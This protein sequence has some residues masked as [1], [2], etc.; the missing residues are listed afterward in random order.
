MTFPKK[1]PATIPMRGRKPKDPSIKNAV[2]TDFKKNEKNLKGFMVAPNRT[3][4][5]VQ[6]NDL[7]G[8][9]KYMVKEDDHGKIKIHGIRDGENAAYQIYRRLEK[10]LTGW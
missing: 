2:L 1:S 10:K 3:I 6:F 4:Y 9:F 5:L 8:E 7:F